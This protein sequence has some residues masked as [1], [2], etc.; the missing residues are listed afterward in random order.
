[1]VP[2]AVLVALVALAA[3]NSPLH[4]HLTSRRALLPRRLF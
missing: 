3:R 1:V 4:T 2:P